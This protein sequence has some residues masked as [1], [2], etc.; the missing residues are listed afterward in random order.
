MNYGQFLYFNTRQFHGTSSNKSNQNR[1]SFDFRILKIND[2]PGTKSY[3][4]FY[5]LYK[6][7]KVKKKKKVIS[8]IYKQNF[9]LSNL[10]HSIQREIIKSYC[11]ANSM[12]VSQEE[13]EIYG[14]D[15][16]PNINHYVDNKKF[17][18]FVLTSILF[19]PKKKQQRRSL[20]KKIYEN[21]MVFHFALENIFTTN[22]N[23]NKIENHYVKLTRTLKSV[24]NDQ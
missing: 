23:F 7:I 10:N 15:H 18:H 24:S 1:V 17:K 5:S 6:N 3:D 13:T 16:Y 20:I 19:L 9:L 14:V 12:E 22:D 11:N 2:D 4:D 21:N 8:F